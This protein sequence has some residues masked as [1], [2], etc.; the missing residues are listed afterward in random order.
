MLNSSCHLTRGSRHGLQDP[1]RRK[2]ACED[3]LPEYGNR[4]EIVAVGDL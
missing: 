4:H 3:Y 1:V 2:L